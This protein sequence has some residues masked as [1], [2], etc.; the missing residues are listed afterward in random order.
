M[1]K[2]F[3]NTSIDFV[4]VRRYA[5][6]LTGMLF[7]PGLILLLTRG[8]NYSIEFTGGT[9]VQ[10]RSQ[11]PVDAG[12]VRNGLDAEGVHG[13][14]I[15][16]FGAPNEF[17]VRARTAKV[18]TDADN[19]QA[20][21]A[22]VGTALDRVIGAGKYT[23]E[24]TEAVGPKVGGEL[25]TKALLAI[26]YSFLAVLVYLAYR[27]E[28]RFGLAA[29][30]ATAHDVLGTIMFI[31]L[32]HFEVSLFVVGGVLSVLGLSLNETIIIFDRVRENEKKRV[33]GTL[34]Q[35]LNLSINETLPRTVLTHGTSLSTML[36]LIIFGGEVIRPFA[37][38]M[39]FG[40]FTG[41]F[42]SMYI[43]PSALMLIR[44]RWPPP[45]KPG[46]KPAKAPARGQAQ[47][48]G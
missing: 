20:T 16:S 9:L 24:R 45:S 27:F 44:R 1:R 47:P 4:G 6:G 31:S 23:I 18:G 5:F 3:T 38:V 10:V 7:I 2:L 36:T 11:V 22:A 39:F 8:L 32:M 14:E 26:F 12:A 15:Q 29:I 48:V 43:A 30:C 41:I 46:V 40:V 25:R 34:P 21:A 37:L 19:T 17:V 35:V 33:P 28:W 13:A 42:S